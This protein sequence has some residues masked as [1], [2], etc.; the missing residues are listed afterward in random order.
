MRA[1]LAKSRNSTKSRLNKKI[2]LR[3]LQN[4][5]LTKNAFANVCAEKKRFAL[6]AVYERSGI[7]VHASGNS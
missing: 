7:M 2:S 4:P 3:I 1:L 6:E 5:D